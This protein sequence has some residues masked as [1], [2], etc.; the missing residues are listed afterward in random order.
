MLVN[1]YAIAAAGGG[2]TDPDF[3]SVKALMHFDGTNGSTAM[4]DVRG[5]T[6]TANGGICT[7]TTAQKKFG[8]SSV[9]VPASANQQVYSAAESDF[10][11]GSGP[12]TL[13]MWVRFHNAPA[14]EFI[15]DMRPLGTT[16]AGPIVCTLAGVWNIYLNGAFRISTGTPAQ[17]VSY[18]VAVCRDSSDDTRF[19]VDGTQVGSAYN[20]PA[21]YGSSQNVIFGIP[22]DAPTILLFDGWI[23]DFRLTRGVARYVANFSPP[24]AAFPDS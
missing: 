12:Y 19:F 8:V 21:D 15:C 4:V 2:P 11:L 10:G 3:A 22:S 13:E 14:T 7:L 17:N 6:F 20:D 5:H 1:S 9:R 23:D 18:H 24:V 16:G